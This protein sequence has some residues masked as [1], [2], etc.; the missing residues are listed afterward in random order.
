MPIDRTLIEPSLLT[1]AERAWVD[2]YHAD[3]RALLAPNLEGAVLDWLMQQTE[4]LA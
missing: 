3:T 2:K 1:D 4:P